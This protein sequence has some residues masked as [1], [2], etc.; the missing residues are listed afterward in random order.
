MGLLGY[1]QELV[2]CSRT[3]KLKQGHLILRASTRGFLEIEQ[4]R[5][6]VFGCE[7]RMNGKGRIAWTELHAS[8]G[9]SRTEVDEGEKHHV[10]VLPRYES[11]ARMKTE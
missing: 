1:G 9:V 8:N 5:A 4:E 2:D 3:A 10:D 6:Q 7:E 11:R